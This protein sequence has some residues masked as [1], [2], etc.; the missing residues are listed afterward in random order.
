MYFRALVLL[1]AVTVA[2]LPSQTTAVFQTFGFA[3]PACLTLNADAQ[4]NPAKTLE[5]A[6]LPNEYAYGL[7]ATKRMVVYGFAMY[8]QSTGPTPFTIDT[9]LYRESAASAIVPT[10]APHM[11]GKLT[12]DVTEGWYISEFAAPIV[13]RANSNFWVSGLDADNVLASSLRGGQQSNVPVYW[14]RVAGPW[15]RSVTVSRPGVV[16]LCSES[17]VLT[18]TCVPKL[19]STGFSLDLSN[20]A[21]SSVCILLFGVSRTVGP[22]GMLPSDLS[23]LGFPNSV[24]WVSTDILL[25][26]MTSAAGDHSLSLPLPNDPTLDG[27]QFFVQGLVHSSASGVVSFSNAAYGIA[28][29]N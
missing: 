22:L 21:A 23:T 15:T 6:K 26:G 12:A 8:T 10:V 2:P 25:P 19:P 7:R 11:S 29:T 28:G 24:L 1:G 5:Q 3:S 4:V 13:I 18:A 17:P 9:A 20:A 27:I 14:R 16:I